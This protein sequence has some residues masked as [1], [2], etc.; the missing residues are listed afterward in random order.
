MRIVLLD[1]D[2]ELAVLGR[3]LQNVPA[4]TGRVMVCGGAGGDRQV[5][6]A[7]GR[8]AR[9]RGPRRG[10]A[11][12]ARRAARAERRE[13]GLAAAVFAGARCD[14]QTAERPPAARS[15]KRSTSP[16]AAACACSPAALATSCAP[17]APDHAAPHSP[18]STR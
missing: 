15:A 1:R 6:P 3:Q 12:R 5:K 10:R 7:A 4:G 14:E 8:R 16:T 13:G 9:G 17:P 2:D 18:A 11:A